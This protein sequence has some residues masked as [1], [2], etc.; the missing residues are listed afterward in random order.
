[1]LPGSTP[2]SLVQNYLRVQEG[3]VDTLRPESVGKL[4]LTVGE[5]V[6]AIV[7]DVL[8]NGR[9]AVLVKDQL[10]DMNLPRNTQPGSKLELTVLEASPRIRFALSGG[11]AVEGQALPVALSQTGQRLAA[12]LEQFAPPDKAAVPTAGAP[13][14]AD[15]QPDIPQLA[16]QLAARLGESGLFYESHQAEW[17]TGT[18]SLPQLLAEPQSNWSKEAVGS[19]ANHPPA[20][21]TMH[22]ASEP[23]VRQSQQ[24]APTAAGP[25]DGRIPMTDPQGRGAQLADAQA[26]SL[27]QMV[28]QQLALLEQRPLVWQGQAWAGQPLEWTLN[29]ERDARSPDG[30]SADDARIWQSRMDL[31][32]PRLGSLTVLTRMHQGE[33]SVRIVI[34]DEAGRSEFAVALPQLAGRFAAAGLPLVQAQLSA[35]ESAEEDG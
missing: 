31:Q 27:R 7:Q 17:V 9:F 8:P 15:E 14:I 35:S 22:D 23:V 12:L 29:W 18:R 34:P 13:L 1:M 33:F 4:L 20:G 2:V 32:L 6:Q 16:R 25:E 21:K 3:L 10:L 28:Q 5:R 19:A 26:A 24:A 30:A 11:A